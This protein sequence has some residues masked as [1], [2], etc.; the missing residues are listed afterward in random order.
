M[1]TATYERGL[2]TRLSRF[3]KSGVTTFKLEYLMQPGFFAYWFNRYSHIVMGILDTNQG[4][5]AEL[6]LL[7]YIYMSLVHGANG[8]LIESVALFMYCVIMHKI[9]NFFL[10][11]K[12][13]TK[14]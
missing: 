11:C 2:S 5:S 6:Y 14:L 10:V 12:L 7:I 13:E 4:E 3:D 8:R 9:G 1:G